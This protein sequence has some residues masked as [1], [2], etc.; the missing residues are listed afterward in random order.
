MT[1]PRT[2]LVWRDDFATGVQEIDDQHMIL[3]ETLS[4]ART[5]LA[6]EPDPETLD[7]LTSDLLSYALYHFETE[8]QLMALHRYAVEDAAAAEKHLSEHR[9]FSATVVAMRDEMGRGGQISP[10]TLIGFLEEWLTNHILN[11][12]RKLGAFIL[13]HPPE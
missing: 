4:E 13:A 11:T 2:P 6:D 8:E 1:A 7:G 3:V 9:D 5:L 10:D 12:D